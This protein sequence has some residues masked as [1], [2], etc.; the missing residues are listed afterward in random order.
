MAVD[1][2]GFVNNN[3]NTFTAASVSNDYGNGNGS[4]GGKRDHWNN[5]IG[6]GRWAEERGRSRHRQAPARPHGSRN[7]TVEN[8]ASLANNRKRHRRDFLA[9][10]EA[11]KPELGDHATAATAPSEN[12]PRESSSSMPRPSSHPSYPRQS[13]APSSASAQGSRTREACQPNNMCNN[14]I[15]PKAQRY[16]PQATARSQ[17]ASNRP[18]NYSEYSSD[19]NTNASQGSSSEQRL[20]KTNMIDEQDRQFSRQHSRFDRQSPSSSVE[21]PTIASRAT[22]FSS[23]TQSAHSRF[24]QPSNKRNYDQSRSDFSNRS[25]GFRRD[26]DNRDFPRRTSFQSN[27]KD[28]YNHHGMDGKERYADLGRPQGRPHFNRE[29][30]NIDNNQPR[31]DRRNGFTFTSQERVRSAYQAERSTPPSRF[32]SNEGMGNRT[33]HQDYS[34]RFLPDNR[35]R[36]LGYRG[37]D[38]FRE[39]AIPPSHNV[40]SERIGAIE[41]N[42]PTL[43]L[44][45]NASARSRFSRWGPRTD[46]SA[47]TTSQSDLRQPRRDSLDSQTRREPPSFAR[48]TQFSPASQPAPVAMDCTRNKML[49]NAASLSAGTSSV[50][51]IPQVQHQSNISRDQSKRIPPRPEIGGWQPGN[52]SHESDRSSP[53]PKKRFRQDLEYHL[54]STDSN[55]N[56]VVPINMDQKTTTEERVL[57]VV[58]ALDTKDE[59]KAFL[60]TKIPPKGVPILN[61]GMPTEEQPIA[62]SSRESDARQ[63]AAIISP[64][65][66]TEQGQS[67]KILSRWLKPPV[68][69]KRKVSAVESSESSVEKMHPVT[70]P[71]IHTTKASEGDEHVEPTKTKKAYSPASP[72]NN[73]LVTDSEGGS[74]ISDIRE[75]SIMLEHRKQA[76]ATVP[77]AIVTAPHHEDTSDFAKSPIEDEVKVASASVVP[78][79]KSRSMTADSESCVHKE[80]TLESDDSSSSSSDESDTDDEEVMMWASKMFGVP[81]RPPPSAHPKLTTTD[82]KTI[83]SPLAKRNP[84]KLHLKLSPS[85]RQN[86]DDSTLSSMQHDKK[87]PVNRVETQ[88]M[89]GER[90]MKLAVRGRKKNKGSMVKPIIISPEDREVNEEK[91]RREREEEKRIREEAKPLTAAQIKEILGDDDYQGTGRRNWVRRSVRQPS[92]ALLNSKQMK[93]L[94]HGLTTNDPDMVVLKMKKYISD[95]NA[96]S[97]VLDAALEA[98]EENTNCEALY[99]QNFN[100]GLRDKQ[101]LHLLRILQAP[102]CKIWCL[103]IGE[104]YN[105]DTETWE[106]FTEGLQRT[107]VTHMYAS[108]HTITTEMKDMIRETIRLNRKKHDMHINPNNL[109][110]IV[111]CTHCWWNP[112]NAKALRPYIKNRGYEYILNDKEVQGLRGSTSEAPNM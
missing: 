98:L 93:A 39:S 54:P 94:V 3:L 64:N 23:D 84:L 10:P 69:K 90:S 91:D 9:R 26:L 104:N 80:S 97:C 34:P 16:L 107:K 70:K 31:E 87:K 29:V 86:N 45:S 18:R 7:W 100:E 11:H 56:I 103:N 57:K 83:H 111:Q 85:K 95:P 105:V 28:S 89:S 33:R 72:V 49:S 12:Y 55:P 76:M 82:Q 21:R 38:N 92:R 32:R 15:P 2:R 102:S 27:M 51:Q 67:L 101:V 30:R 8:T 35:P 36:E 112:I 75:L 43:Q 96:P 59:S 13:Q 20:E 61:Q 41:S 106:K 46:R 77:C 68:E 58:H 81:Y 66:T 6:E 73:R 63:N 109:D 99:I 5:A 37:R 25:P 53:P 48:Q 65:A 24:Q 22:S 14:F 74:T 78:S 108:E 19:R 40:L 50:T 4:M 17:F 47:L 1:G 71:L 79:V 88:N 62:S 44:S 52:I 110:V 60:S 42:T